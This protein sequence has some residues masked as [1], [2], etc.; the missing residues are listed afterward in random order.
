MEL[1][2]GGI[3]IY[4]TEAI[5][6]D[7]I[8]KTFGKNRGVESLN[9]SVEP[10][11]IV[12]F[13]GPNG[14]G[15]TTTINMLM[16][17]TKPTSGKALIF[18][19]DVLNHGPATRRQIG[20]LSSDMALDDSLTG[21]QELEYLGSLYGDYDKPYMLELANRLD[22]EL[23]KKIRNLSRGNKQKI[24]LVSALMH[25]PDILILDEPTSGLDPLIQATF[26]AI[27]LEHR[28]AGR[29]AF[30]SSHVLSEVEELC[31]RF[32]FIREGRIIADK[33]LAQLREQTA[34]QVTIRSKNATTIK[35]QLKNI[36]GIDQ[37]SIASATVSFVFTGE[38][39]DLVRMLAKQD[40]Q[41][42][43]I[44]ETDLEQVFMN[45]YE[46]EGV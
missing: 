14:A 25:K 46:G 36:P 24:G 26:N 30:I 9:L 22:A 33:T 18:G 19:R 34:R 16:G 27:I 4:M 31:D 45:Y 21:R 1:Y 38:I 11:E 7:K 43:R 23:D 42:L 29:T 8:T 44:S 6:L 3:L 41:S 37:L 39:N 20:F 17:F 32:V 40:I 12:G 10:G 15:K 13:L 28:K 2:S 5:C 35:N